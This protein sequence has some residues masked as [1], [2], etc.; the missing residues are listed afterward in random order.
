V[1]H[2]WW[3]QATDF[4]K[5]DSAGAIFSGAGLAGSTGG[6][7]YASN[8]IIIHPTSPNPDFPGDKLGIGC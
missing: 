5:I 7:C 2:Q 1:N 6:K 8:A 3:S 4:S